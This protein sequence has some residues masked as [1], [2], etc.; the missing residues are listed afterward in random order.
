MTKGKNSI[1]AWQLVATSTTKHNTT[2]VSSDTRIS[3]Y[4]C[5]NYWRSLRYFNF[6]S[7]MWK[8]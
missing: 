6:N 1:Q 7:N 2:N 4:V 3:C 5:Y 8:C